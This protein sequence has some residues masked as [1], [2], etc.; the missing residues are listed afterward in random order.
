MLKG[1]L[2]LVSTV[3]DSVSISAFVLLVCTPVGIATSA[4]GLNKF[5]G[6]YK[7]YKSKEIRIKV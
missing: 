1:C 7:K 4:V 2:I 5:I 3:T 6:G